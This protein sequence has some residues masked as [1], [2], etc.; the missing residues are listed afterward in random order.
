[1][2][3]AVPTLS[4]IAIKF[5]MIRAFLK[6]GAIYTM[7]AFLS[8]GTALILF[9][10]YTRSLGLEDY[11]HFDLLLAI[12]SLVFLTVALEVSQG[13]ARY[14]SEA[15][16]SWEGDSM[17][18]S[19]ALFALLA[20]TAFGI[21][22]AINAEYLAEL[23]F[24]AGDLGDFFRVGCLY[25]MCHGLLIHFQNQL[26]WERR[27]TAYAISTLVTFGVTII[28]TIWLL[29]I[30]E[31]DLIACILGLTSGSIVGLVVTLFLVQRTITSSP[32]LPY[33]KKMLVFSAPLVVSSLS[34][35]VN[36]F[37]DRI[38]INEMIN[39]QEL[40]IYAA[41][42]KISS[43][44]LLFVT[45]FQSSVLPL[46]Y[47][48][49]RNEKF[50]S[51][52]T[53]IFYIYMSIS[54]LIVVSMVLFRAEIVALLA[55]GYLGDSDTVILLLAPALLIS[56]LY[57]FYPGIWIEKRTRVIAGINLFTAVVNVLLN[58]FLIPT[59]GIVGAA[60]ATLL[61][62]ALSLFMYFRFESRIFRGSYPWLIF[63][64]IF[65]IVSMVG[66]Y[67]PALMPPSWSSCAVRI[68]LL[69][70]TI[71]A[72]ASLCLVRW[73][74]SVSGLRTA[75]NRRARTRKLDAAQRNGEQK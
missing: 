52:M 26:R 6:D 62:A 22:A 37:V 59:L 41:A 33:L 11:G 34:I 9:P 61:C 42:V 68:L 32:S 40:G 47:K 49:Y 55:P 44:S 20:Y 70:A 53:D 65:V 5:P 60:L 15:T 14:Y 75:H 38:M 71:L 74:S 23:I 19:A 72:L 17:A 63:V 45:G 18:A 39:S 1:V 54:T 13:L 35:W 16:G 31:R 69:A 64:S 58:L 28:S 27:G 2:A 36:S 51:Y 24:N 12:A 73:S 29:A 46:I 3:G 8:K 25:F 4:Q 48:N 21:L 7:T 67:T 66:E 56:Q 30:M 10:I 43:I 57:I 50:G